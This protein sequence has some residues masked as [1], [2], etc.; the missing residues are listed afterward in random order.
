WAHDGWYP[1]AGATSRNAGGGAAVTGRGA[2]DTARG[3]RRAGASLDRRPPLGTGRDPADRTGGGDRGRRGFDPGSAAARR[4]PV[5]RRRTRRLEAPPAGFR[6]REAGTATPVA[7]PG[8][9]VPGGALGVA[10]PG[11]RSAP[12]QIGAGGGHATPGSGA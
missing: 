9:G 3:G 7:S 6:H 2:H 8:P 1:S 10:P 11:G 4:D 5:G 12:C